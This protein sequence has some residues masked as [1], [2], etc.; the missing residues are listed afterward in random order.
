MSVIK[1]RTKVNFDDIEIKEVAEI[2]SIIIDKDAIYKQMID[3]CGGDETLLI[4]SCLRL[5]IFAPKDKSNIFNKISA[6][7]SQ[8]NLRLQQQVVGADVASDVPTLL[9]MQRVMAADISQYII[10]KNLPMWSCPDCPTA[11]QFAGAFE[12]CQT[13]QQMASWLFFCQFATKK[14]GFPTSY[15]K[16]GI[17]WWNAQNEDKI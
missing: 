10:E 5:S 6:A 13:R 14:G 1:R 7:E 2:R 3:G 8:Q 11:L 4:K 17:K 9:R 12:L 16:T 15:S